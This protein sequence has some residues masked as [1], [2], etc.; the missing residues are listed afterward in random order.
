MKTVGRL[1]RRQHRRVR[2]RLA[3]A[4]YKGAHRKHALDAVVELVLGF[5]GPRSTQ[6]DEMAVSGMCR[7]PPEGVV[8]P[9]ACR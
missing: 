1:D 2:C 4:E 6:H 3:I 9:V 7:E 5:R 8:G